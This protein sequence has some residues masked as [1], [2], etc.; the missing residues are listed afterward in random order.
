MGSKKVQIL[1]SGQFSSNLPSLGGKAFV[2]ATMPC[3]S[4]EGRQ[5]HCLCLSSHTHLQCSALSWDFT[6]RIDFCDN[7][8]ISSLRVR[9]W[10]SLKVGGLQLPCSETWEGVRVT[11]PPPTIDKS[12]LLL[13]LQLLFEKSTQQ[14]RNLLRK[15]FCFR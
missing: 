11:I 8:T 14:T 3:S 15:L 10:R 2:S 4:P 12:Q 7:E 6:G 13:L 5:T 1:K 9:G